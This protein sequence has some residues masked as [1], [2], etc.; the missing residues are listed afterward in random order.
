M[1]KCGEKSVE[2][3]CKENAE[4]VE[5][6]LEQKPKSDCTGDQHKSGGCCS[7]TAD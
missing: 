1:C 2:K 6:E 3:S 7:A 5:V 4:V